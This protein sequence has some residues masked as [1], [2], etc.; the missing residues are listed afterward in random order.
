MEQVT[1]IAADF[2]RLH[3]RAVNYELVDP[4]A[5]DSGFEFGLGVILDGL[6]ARLASERPHRQAS[7]RVSLTRPERPDVRRPA[8]RSKRQAAVP[9][10]G[11][12]HGY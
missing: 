9:R 2:P 4:A 12:R 5:A 7:R 8:G 1:A 10:A 11:P 3:A 6:E